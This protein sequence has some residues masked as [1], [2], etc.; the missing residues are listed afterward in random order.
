[1]FGGTVYVPSGPVREIDVR[2]LTLGAD[3][4]HGD[5]RITAEL[6]QRRTPDSDLLINDRSAYITVARRLAR[7]T[8]YVT[9]ARLLSRSAGRDAFRQIYPTPVPLGAQGPPLFV[10]ENFHRLFGDLLAVNDQR[11]VMLGASYSFTPTSK[12]KLEWMR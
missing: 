12:L 11:S 10:P 1:P 3:W 2:V 6:A 7:W 4:R 5:W 9:Y 8:P